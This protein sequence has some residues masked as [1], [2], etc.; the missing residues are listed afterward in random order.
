MAV[1]MPHNQLSTIARAIELTEDALEQVARIA[2]EGIHGGLDASSHVEAGE[3]DMRN[4]LRQLVLAER[5]LHSRSELGADLEDRPGRI[6]DV[7]PGPGSEAVRR[8]T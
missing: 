1:G 4:A 8:G 5:E 2:V 6:A 3:R 7:V